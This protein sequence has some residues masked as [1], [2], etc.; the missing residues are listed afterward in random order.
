LLSIAF[1]KNRPWLAPVPHRGKQNQPGYVVE[2]AEFI[3]DLKGISVKEL[4]RITT[5]NFYTL[6]ALAKK[7]AA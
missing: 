7:S 5:E 2:V 1:K 4:A 3:A 6:F